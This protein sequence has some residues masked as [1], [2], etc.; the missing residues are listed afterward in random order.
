MLK[1]LLKNKILLAAL[2][3]IILCLTA[4]IVFRVSAKPETVLTDMQP[5]PVYFFNPITNKLEPE[6]RNIK[7]GDNG[8]AAI[9]VLNMLYEGP[10]TQ[11]L[12]KIAPEE[13]SIKEV[14]IKGDELLLE[15][16]E[17]YYAL[18]P[19]DELLFKASLV[20]TLTELHF[21]RSVHIYVEGQELLKNDGTPYGLLTRGN[22]YLAPVISPDKVDLQTIKL[23]FADIKINRLAPEGRMV[24][25]NP[26]QP[27]EKYVM[28]QLLAGT[29]Q[30]G[31][32]N[33]IPPETKIISVK[34]DEG[35]CYVNLSAD[36][37]SKQSG[38]PEIVRL[39]VYSIVNSLTE[40]G[41]VKKVQFWIDNKV[42]EGF[43]GIFDLSKQIDRDESVIRGEP[44]DSE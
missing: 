18:K 24:Q 27:R 35:I 22:V 43:S 20:Y 23:Y 37:I 32:S 13:T 15:F 25:V 26:D 28:E 7:T 8:Q 10:K 21:V 16:T 38:S 41:N 2:P 6:T 11:A 34:T 31:L 4:V 40:L 14:S 33:V 9:D 42:V 17:G 39:S 3:V 30:S 1:K 5:V 36:F 44:E 19:M 12:V 29:T